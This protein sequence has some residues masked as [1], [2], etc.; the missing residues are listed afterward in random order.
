[1]RRFAQQVQGFPHMSAAAHASCCAYCGDSPEAGERLKVCSKCHNMRYC[2][3][4]CQLRHWRNGHRE[5][6]APT[7][8]LMV[9][10]SPGSGTPDILFGPMS[11]AQRDLATVSFRSN[12]KASRS[13]KHKSDPDKCFTAMDCAFT[14]ALLYQLRNKWGECL[15]FMDDFAGW[16]EAYK[17]LVPEGSDKWVESKTSALQSCIAKNRQLVEA[18][19]FGVKNASAVKDVHAVSVG[20][21]RKMCKYA[22]AEDLLREQAAWCS[23]SVAI[24]IDRILR[25]GA[26]CLFVINGSIKHEEFG[27]G[28]CQDVVFS[29][30]VIQ[31]TLAIMRSEDAPAEYKSRA[32]HLKFFLGQEG[33]FNVLQELAALKF[34]LHGDMAAHREAA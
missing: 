33:Y 2:N 9:A 26:T 7:M 11:D 31:R 12:S 1:M 13:V 8:L 28:F 21:T 20:A 16:L 15:G 22:L 14:L 18:V 24:N 25:L 34:Q 23:L 4:Q 19:V 29:L 30:K 6:C 10:E 3:K 27:E 5:H 32:R 17:L